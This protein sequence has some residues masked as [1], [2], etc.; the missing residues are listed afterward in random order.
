MCW[1]SEEIVTDMILGA[2]DAQKID[3]TDLM[4]ASKRLNGNL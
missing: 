1:F 3:M 2:C 4:D